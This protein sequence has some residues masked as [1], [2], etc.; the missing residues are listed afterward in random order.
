IGATPLYTATEEGHFEVVELLVRNG[1]DINLSPQGTVAKE[2]RIENQTP[3]LIACMKNF[4]NIIKFLIENGANVNVTSD[5]GSSPFLAIC[6]HNNV[7]LATLLIKHGARYDVEAYNLYDGKINGLIVAA[8]SGSFDILK[9]LVENGLDVNYKIEGKGET[10]GR[11]P[12]F[13]ACAKGYQNIVQYLIQKGADVNGTEKSGLSCL[14]IASAMDH[15]ETVRILCEN[16][17]NIDQQF[18]LED[19]EWTAY[20]LAEY[21]Q[22]ENV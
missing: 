5:R 19:Q 7:D 2:L 16:G 4:E 13:C 9:L 15:G 11:T 8:E 10:A 6:Q 14:H 3:L 22:H 1:A 17:A 12:L 21:Q 18:Y 20:D